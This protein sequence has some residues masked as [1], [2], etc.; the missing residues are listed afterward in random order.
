MDPLLHRL[1]S[2][3]HPAWGLSLTPFALALHPHPPGPY[4]GALAI[5]FKNWSLDFVARILSTRISGAPAGPS[6]WS[7]R[8]SR[9]TSAS[10]PA[11]SSSSSFRVLDASTL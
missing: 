8:R 10:S 6:A 2:P 11:G 3:C 4:A 5:S 7:T 9:H 1:V